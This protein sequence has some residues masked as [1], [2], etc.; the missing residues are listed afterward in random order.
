MGKV[1]DWRSPSIAQAF[2]G[3]DNADFAQ[4]FLRRNPD[5]RRDFDEACAQMK[6]RGSDPD[7]EMEG[8]ARR[9]GM[10]FPV[11]ARRVSGGRTCALDTGACCD[12]RDRRC[13]AVRD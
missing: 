7:K 8:L 3:H 6:A 4:E 5:Y 12:N 11:S 10:T 2:V 13:C 1:S 9:W